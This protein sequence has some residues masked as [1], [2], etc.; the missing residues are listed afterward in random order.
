MLIA[1]EP[2]GNLDPALSV[3]IM[4]LFALFNQV[5]VTVLI[6]SHDHRLIERLGKRYLTLDHGRLVDGVLHGTA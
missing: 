6:A 1:D 2:T 5:G 4:Q 3:E